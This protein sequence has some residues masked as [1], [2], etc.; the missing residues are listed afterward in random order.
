[1]LVMSVEIIFLLIFLTSTDY[2]LEILYIY[3]VKQ[4]YTNIRKFTYSYFKFRMR[5]SKMDKSSMKYQP[6][7]IFYIQSNKWLLSIYHVPDPML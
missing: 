4:I 1:M 3:R 7:L 2:F 5:I 6:Y